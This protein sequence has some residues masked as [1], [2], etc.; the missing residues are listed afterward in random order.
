MVPKIIINYYYLLLI[1]INH[2]LV[3]NINNNADIYYL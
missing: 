2:L 3:P 1:I